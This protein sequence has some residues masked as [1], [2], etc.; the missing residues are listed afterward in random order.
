MMSRTMMLELSIVGGLVSLF[1]YY[2]M[3]VL[4]WIGIA[5]GVGVAGI[6]LLLAWFGFITARSISRRR[7]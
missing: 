5:A 7:L 2:D 4:K 3:R 6:V 1:A